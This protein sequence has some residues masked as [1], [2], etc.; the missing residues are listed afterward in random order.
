M[1]DARRAPDP[2]AASRGQGPVPDAFRAVHEAPAATTIAKPAHA[3]GPITP[4]GFGPLFANNQFLRL[5]LAQIISQ[6]IMNAANYGMIVLVTKVSNSSLATSGAIVSFSIPALFLSVPA[7]AIVDRFDRR[8][9]LW[10]S[11]ALRAVAA[12]VFVV[13]LLIAPNALWPVYALTFFIAMVGQ[14]F[15]PAE[16]AAIPRLVRRDDLMNAL[17][18]F[19]ITF[20]LAQAAGL[21]ILGPLALVLIPAF[22]L[23]GQHY[24]VTI[25]PIVSL[26]VI[27]TA[28]YALCAGLV[29]S[30]PA[31]SLRAAKLTGAE[32][33]AMADLSG[34]RSRRPSLQEE[35]KTESLGAKLRD[36]LSD[37]SDSWRFIRQDDTLH[38]AAWQLTL[39]GV[40]ISVVATVATRFVQDY[41]HQ[42]PELAALVFLPAGVGLVLGSVATPWVVRRLRY[43]WTIALG[44]GLLVAAPTLLVIGRL[45][46]PFIYGKVGWW[47]HWPYIAWMLLLTFLIGIGLDF[48]NVPAQTILQDRSPDWIKGR[49]FAVQYLMLYAVTVVY[50]PF[51]GWLA[52]HF[53]LSAAL[54]VVALTVAAAGALTVYLRLKISRRERQRISVG[55]TYPGATGGGV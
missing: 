52:D 24:G 9:V 39:A 26:F 44:I 36:I 27:V 11:N 53:G 31:A 49:V 50:V 43:T 55:G 25:E 16:G 38:I 4:R 8:L 1:A 40:V 48:V 51:I 15:T 28:L 42:R 7:G 30:I 12:A 23:G 46:A 47:T 54:L 3:S 33:A 10:V 21:I 19:N 32:R 20:T 22:R 2:Q 37:I 41:F 5:W 17:A 29:L 45:T 6:T 34:P 13:T 18:L 35:Q 14:F